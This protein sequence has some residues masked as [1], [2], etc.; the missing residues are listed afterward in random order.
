MPCFYLSTSLSPLPF[1][2]CLVPTV[3]LSSPDETFLPTRLEYT[4]RITPETLT[5]RVLTSTH[6]IEL[7]MLGM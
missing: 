3:L 1:R 4:W 7:I 5:V 6:R 2:P